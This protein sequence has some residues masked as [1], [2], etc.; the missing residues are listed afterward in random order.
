MRNPFEFGRELNATELVDRERETVQVRDTVDQA[1]KLFLIGPR[2]FGKTSILKAAED[3]LRKDGAIVLHFDLERYPSLDLLVQHLI[4]SAALNLKGKVERISAQIRQ[5]FSRLRPEITFNMSEEIWTAK[6]GLGSSEDPQQ[7]VALL[8]DALDGFEALAAAQ[9][10][11]V[12]IGVVFDEFQRISEMGGVTAEGQ[13]RAAIQKH[14]RVGYVFAGS[15]TKLMA[16]MTM[17]PE[18]PFYRLGSVHFIGPVPRPDFWKF[19]HDQFQKGGFTVGDPAAIDAIL[20]LAEEVPYNVQMLAHTCWNE[21]RGE[22]SK[23]PGVLTTKFVEETVKLIVLQ[24]DPFFTQVWTALTPTQQKTLLA[25]IREHGV[26]LHSRRVIH[27]IGKSQ[28][29]VQRA[30]HALAE[31]NIVRDE[32]HNGSIRLRFEDPFF[33]QWIRQT[34]AV[35][36]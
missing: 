3:H 26:G 14:R 7:H 17:N 9:P 6:I 29:T 12:A 19:L 11:S 34:V 21:L 20:D 32:E 10:K 18:R 5:F 27:A 23:R 4:S 16:D 2:R 35:G 24:F 31:R 36:L 1:N 25:A 28:S 22:G 30:L 8:V 15:K 13:I 33:A